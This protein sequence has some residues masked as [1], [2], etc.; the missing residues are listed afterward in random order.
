[1]S[2]VLGVLTEEAR[3]LLELGF[4][5]HLCLHMHRDGSARSSAAVRHRW[6]EL[7]S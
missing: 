2:R 6:I 5:I 7:G 1:M 4:S 3:P